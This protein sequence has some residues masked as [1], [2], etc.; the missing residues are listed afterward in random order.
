VRGAFDLSTFRVG[1]W[2]GC[3][4]FPA[5]FKLGLPLPE[6]SLYETSMSLETLSVVG[7][8][9]GR[10]VLDRPFLDPLVDETE[11]LG[12]VGGHERVAVQRVL[13]ILERLTGV[14]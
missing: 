1:D 8:H 12:H 14:S 10:R 9:L 4:A 7:L 13:D 5:V 11:I 3:G 2:Q 6:T